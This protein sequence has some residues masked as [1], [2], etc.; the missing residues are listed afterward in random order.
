MTFNDYQKLAVRTC[1][2]YD[3]ND[4]NL[5]HMAIGLHSEYNELADAI[6]KADIV[7]I[8]EEI[9]DHFWYLAVYCHFIDYQFNH[10]VKLNMGVVDDNLSVITSQFCDVVKKKVIYGKRSVDLFVQE[11]ELMSKIIEKLFNIAEYFV[12]DVEKLLINNIEKLKVRFPEKY[13]D[14]SANNRNLDAEYEQLKK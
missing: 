2:V 10:C 12:I 1:K 11:K 4:V 5:L 3:N 9:A 7:N 13:T 8:G 14:I 6:D